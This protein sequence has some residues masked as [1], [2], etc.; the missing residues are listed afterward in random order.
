MVKIFINDNILIFKERIDIYLPKAIILRMQKLK[1]HNDKLLIKEL[2]EGNNKAFRALF[3]MYRNDVYAYS[4]SMLKSKVYAEEIVQDVFLKVWQF[5]ERIDPKLSF[6]S[7][8]FTITR[9]LTFNFISKAATDKKLR[10]EVFYMSQKFYTPLSERVLEVDYEALKNKAIDQLPPKRKLIFELSRN[11][12]MTY[13][14][15]SEHLGISIST[16]KSQ[17]SKALESIKKFLFTNADITFVLTMM[18]S[19]WLE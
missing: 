11:E 2:V 1:T 9:N 18:T 16:V 5:R 8:I 6:K 14:E 3:D 19:R 7:Y 17:M 13:E 15:I 12:G 4:F 10:E